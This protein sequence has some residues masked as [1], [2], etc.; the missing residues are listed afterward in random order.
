M[1]RPGG[2][3]LALDW[4]RRTLARSTTSST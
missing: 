2:D 1:L 3:K 4:R